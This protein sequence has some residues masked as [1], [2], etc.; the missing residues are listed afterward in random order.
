MIDLAQFPLIAFNLTDTEWD[1]PVLDSYVI[2]QVGKLKVALVGMTYP[3]TALTSAVAGSG[4]DFKFGIKENLAIEV[5]TS[6]ARFSLIPNLKSLP[7]PATAEVR[8]VQG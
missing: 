1:E 5:M 3:W 7:D 6:I 8:A 2:R 4:R